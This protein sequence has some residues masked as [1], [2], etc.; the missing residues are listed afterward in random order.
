M[1]GK[2]GKGREREG[3]ENFITST[4]TLRSRVFNP[5]FYQGFVCVCLGL[6]LG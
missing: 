6:D 5:S 3:D 1:M 4:V 2:E